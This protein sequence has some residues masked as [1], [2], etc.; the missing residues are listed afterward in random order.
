MASEVVKVEGE[1][2]ATSGCLMEDTVRWYVGDSQSWVRAPWL[3]R[4]KDL[5][6]DP[7]YWF[8]KTKQHISKLVQIVLSFVRFQFCSTSLFYP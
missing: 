4:E 2:P 6:T 5:Q 3:T 7:Q 1:D 8:N